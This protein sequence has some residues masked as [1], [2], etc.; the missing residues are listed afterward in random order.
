MEDLRAWRR[1][2]VGRTSRAVEAGME[3][4]HVSGVDSAAV[5]EADGE[6]PAWTR[7]QSVRRQCGP[8]GG[9]GGA[10]SR[11]MQRSGHTA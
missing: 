11:Q 4:E 8:D 5:R 7:Q 9:R 2:R 1:K 3:K 10:A 6:A